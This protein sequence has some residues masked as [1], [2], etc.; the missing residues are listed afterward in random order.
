MSVKD[1]REQFLLCYSLGRLLKWLKFDCT[2]CMF[3]AYGLLFATLKK[4]VVWLGCWHGSVY[5]IDLLWM[6]LVPFLPWISL[7]GPSSCVGPIHWFNNPPVPGAVALVMH[8]LLCVF[9]LMFLSFFC[10]W[11]YTWKRFRFSINFCLIARNLQTQTFV[12]DISG[13]IDQSYGC[14]D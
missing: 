8:T 13:G 1:H 14:I 2:T 11:S 9:R 12:F 6:M 5:R 4:K 10:R 7:Y 3:N